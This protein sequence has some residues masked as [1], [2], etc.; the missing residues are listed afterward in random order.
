MIARA[1]M[2]LR[3]GASFGIEDDSYDKIQWFDKVQLKP[4][5]AEVDAE[6]ARLTQIK[7]DNK[8]QEDRAKEYPPIETQ[9]DMQ[10]WDSMNGT[11]IWQDTIAAIKAKYP[12]SEGV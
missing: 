2:N 9:L 10:Y 8:Y 3:P 5:K 6:I 7:I 11:T 1:I 12:K 4:T